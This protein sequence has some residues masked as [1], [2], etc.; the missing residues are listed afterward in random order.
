MTET[1]SIFWKY[2]L[3]FPFK[4]KFLINA[5]FSFLLRNVKAKLENPLINV[6]VYISSS[7]SPFPIEY[8]VKKKYFVTGLYF[9]PLIGAAMLSHSH[10]QYSC[11][12]QDYTILPEIKIMF[13]IH[14]LRQTDRKADRRT[15]TWEYNNIECDSFSKKKPIWQFAIRSFVCLY[16]FQYS[17]YKLQ[18]LNKTGWWGWE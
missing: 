16:G 17:I 3:Y 14:R 15:E 4:N 13:E 18:S 2:S 5:I 10:S 1:I 9:C 6:E 12:L 11:T 7:A 8:I